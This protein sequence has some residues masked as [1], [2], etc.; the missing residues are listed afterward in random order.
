[1]MET[2][3]ITGFEQVAFNSDVSP[4]M[5]PV[6]ALTRAENAHLL[7]NRVY[8]IG[9]YS[10]LA[11][12]PSLFDPGHSIFV[13]NDSGSYWVICGTGVENSPSA[14]D[15]AVYSYDGTNF[16]DVS[17]SA[18]IY[19]NL[20]NPNYWTSCLFNNKP[21]IN[22]PQS[23][24]QTQASASASSDFAEIYWDGTTTWAT[25]GM[26]CRA[27]ASHKEFLF[28]MDMTESAV[29]LPYV[30]RWSDAADPGAMPSSWD[31][32]VPTNLAG[33]VALSA[34]GGRCLNGKSLRDSFIVYRE[35]SIHT[36]DFV[37]GQYVFARRDLSTT[38][39]MVGRHAV[40]ELNGVHYFISQGD[41]YKNDGSSITSILSNKNKLYFLSNA[42]QEDISKSFVFTVPLIDEVWFCFPAGSSSVN[43]AL[44]YNV[45]SESFTT[46]SLTPTYHIASGY[47]AST[48]ELW[49]DMT[50]NWEDAFGS[51]FVNAPGSMISSAYYC[52]IESG[53]TKSRLQAL[54]TIGF[55]TDVDFE[56]IIERSSLR[57]TDSDD[58][59]TILEMYPHHN[60]GGDT[61]YFSIGTQDYP[62]G[63]IT[64]HPEQA[65]SQS[66]RK[67]DIRA[68]GKYFAYRFRSSGKAAWYLA[69]LTFKYVHDGVR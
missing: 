61:I 37:G 22:H 54:N 53:A 65:I 12:V 36:F 38:I 14:D 44:V 18:A 45:A 21:V 39:G 29:E 2:L 23:Y 33:K 5:L 6:N 28:A 47:P 19:S 50:D 66:L 34:E 55:A 63:A 26:S 69:G 59:S 17:S 24:P 41:I 43:R 11:E 35:N 60:T 3:H 13:K 8:A 68:T 10:D 32:T 51:W 46:V 49:S 9:G 48:V 31:E 4:D 1:M 56:T 16:T 40:A 57:I 67:L 27:I 20:L 25:A 58:S 64:W 15:K 42:S 30:V 7:T 62:Y 52:T